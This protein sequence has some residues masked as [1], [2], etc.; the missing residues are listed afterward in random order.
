MAKFSN[1]IGVSESYKVFNIFNSLRFLTNAI[2]TFKN[3]CIKDIKANEAMCQA[4][5][6]KSVGIVTALLPH[7]GYEQCSALAK[8]ALANERGIKDL[9]LEKNIITAEDLNVILSPKE[10]TEPGIAGKS[11][12]C[13]RCI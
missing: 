11:L 6:D 8:E 5:L 13:K 12:L 1:E 10:M 4:W 3:L 2:D 9:V 7:I